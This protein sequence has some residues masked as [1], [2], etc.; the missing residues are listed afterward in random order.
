MAAVSFI[1]LTSLN[2]ILLLMSGVL[3]IS[4][5]HA[6]HDI[7]VILFIIIS[8]VLLLLVHCHIF[9]VIEAKHVWTLS[10]WNLPMTGHLKYPKF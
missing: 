4:Y 5:Q 7:V 8:D 9:D 3:E 10:V 1:I 6:L 2:I